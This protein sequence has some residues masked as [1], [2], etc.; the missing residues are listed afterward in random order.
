M[1]LLITRA[2]PP[3]A[4]AEVSQAPV[5]RSKPKPP[6]SAAATAG[7]PASRKPVPDAA[8]LSRGT[9]FAPDSGASA[10]RRGASEES[11]ANG[12]SVVMVPPAAPLPE[13]LPAPAEAL[14]SP[15]T[16]AAPALAPA[17]PPSDHPGPKALVGLDEQATVRL[18]GEPSWTEDVPPAKYWQYATPSCV[19]RVFFFMEMT[20]QNFRALSYELTSSDD[21][22]NVHE[23]CFAQLL[24]QASGRQTAHGN[25]IN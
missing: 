21:A 18:L 6:V 3:P 15:A 24:A 22:P 10:E 16:P 14:P 12:G 9:A 17:A 5:P 4:S 1:P 11:E 8:A 2:E 25:R 7:V 19:L 13:P 23:R 20:T